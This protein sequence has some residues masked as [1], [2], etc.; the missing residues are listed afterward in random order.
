MRQKTYKQIEASRNT[1]LWITEV[2]IPV[3]TVG[4][5]VGAALYNGNPELR[6]K[7]NNLFKKK[8][9]KVVEFK[10]K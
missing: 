6:N 9:K 2:I 3:L 10:T 1:R 8:D 7:V 4:C 5:T